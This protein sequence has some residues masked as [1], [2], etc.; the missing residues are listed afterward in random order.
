MSSRSSFNILTNGRPIV[1]HGSTC[2]NRS[3]SSIFCRAYPT[4]LRNQFWGF[5]LYTVQ[6]QGLKASCDGCVEAQACRFMSKQCSSNPVGSR[7]AAS[8]PKLLVS[9]RLLERPALILA[10]RRHFA[11]SV[12]PSCGDLTK[13]IISWQNASLCNRQSW[14]LPYSTLPVDEEALDSRTS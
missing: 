14:T 4:Y 5:P 10:L 7:I 6:A 8:S 2:A 9:S 1:R 13:N 11:A 3:G 12:P